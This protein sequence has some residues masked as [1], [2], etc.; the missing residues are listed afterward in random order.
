[1]K[2]RYNEYFSQAQMA[3]AT[4]RYDMV[5]N[6][7]KSAC[8]L[9]PGATEVYILAGNAYLVEKKLEDAEKCFRKAIELNP[10]AGERYF[11]L[12]NS[13]FGQQKLADA[14]EAYA[15]AIQLGCKDEIMQKIYYI[16]GMINQADGKNRDALLNFEK[17][18]VFSGTN[19]DHADILIRRIQIYIEQNNLQK[20]ENCA[21]QL[22]L[23]VP[24]EFKSYQLLFQLYLEQ[25]KITEAEK[26]LEEAVT[27][28]TSDG[29]MLTEIG[30]DRV[31]LS[32]FKAEQNPDHREQ[33]YQEAIMHLDE[34]ENTGK[35]SEKDQYEALIIQAEIYMKLENYEKALELAK[36]AEEQKKEELKEY[37]ERGR[38]IIATCLAHAEDYQ[39]VI[40]Y[41]SLMKG[42]D[43]SFYRYYGYYAEANASKQ[44]AKADPALK[45]E[46]LKKY[47][48]A[49]AYYKNCTVISPGDF[50]AY[51]FR[52]RSYVDIGKYDKAE[53]IG[54]LLP[55]D[56]Q[57]TLQEYIDTE[58]R[59]CEG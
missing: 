35:L 52:A 25:K 17:S 14:M 28:C 20:A 42:S 37:A 43:N 6:L 32:C 27:Y 54:Q 10:S 51:L 16:V 59:R 29:E 41:A 21:T 36:Q 53:E 45:T 39:G 57:Q 15:R 8:T 5:I 22:K 23:L 24:D 40:T 1:M 12:G 4:G 2:D 19:P 9:E 55:S 33:Y 26:I 46:A 3:Y 7:C 50:M 49:I 30:F 48:Y 58:K 13:L 56:V 11:D 44:L 34:L 47:D 38:F 31:M 18:D